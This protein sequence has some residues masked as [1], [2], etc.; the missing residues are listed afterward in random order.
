MKS[1]QNIVRIVGVLFIVQ[2]TAAIISYS[3]ILE[4]LLQQ[5]SF[6]EQ[7]ASNST[8][9]IV[10]VLLDLVTGA[11]V[12][13]IAVLL[14]PILKDFSERVALWYAGQRLTELMG[15]M[16]SG[17]LV[18]TLLNIGQDI[19]TSSTAS[20]ASHLESLAIYLRKARGSVQDINL[21][22]YSLGA[23]SFY[24]LL[25]YAKLIPP[26]ISA[27]GLIAVTLLFIEIMANVFGTSAGGMLIMMPLGLNEIFLGVWL[28]FKG[29]D[30]TKII[31]ISS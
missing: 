16:L 25:F 11:T 17:V 8:N 30:Q 22:I 27:W 10:A 3:V 31:P 18:L 20:S 28:I 7:L 5:S 23:W 6:L 9:V 15:L 24:G 12:F 26:F 4:P 29:F 2:L 1:T 14:Y 13:A 21:L 19:D